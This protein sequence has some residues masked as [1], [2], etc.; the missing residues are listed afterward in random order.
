MKLDDA[1]RNRYKKGIVKKPPRQLLD[2]EAISKRFCILMSLSLLVVEI[3]VAPFY[4]FF[5][6]KSW[7]CIA[8][9]EMPSPRYR[10]ESERSALRSI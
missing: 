5:H 7:S 6:Y 10:K 8:Q 4:A 9:L 3:V 1:K 2:V